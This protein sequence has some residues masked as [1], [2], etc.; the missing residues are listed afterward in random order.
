MR[1]N[2]LEH[3]IS[4]GTATPLRA[5]TFD[6]ARVAFREERAER[7][8]RGWGGRGRESGGEGR[9][10]VLARARRAACRGSPC[11]RDG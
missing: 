3:L 5:R 1:A 4:M 10:I 9:R 8:Q 11:E 2:M 6:I 7:A